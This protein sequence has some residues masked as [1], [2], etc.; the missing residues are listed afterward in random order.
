[1]SHVHEAGSARGALLHESSLSRVLRI[2]QLVALVI[3]AVIMLL[4]LALFAALLIAV[5]ESAAAYVAVALIL[6]ACLAPVGLLALCVRRGMRLAMR[7]STG[8]IEV[9]GYLRD[10]WEQV[11]RVETSDH[12]YW[13]RATRIV[14]TDGRRVDAVV[15]SYQFLVFRG[16]AYDDTARDPRIPQLPTRIAID[17]HRR[18][19]RGEFAGPR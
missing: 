7:V 6:V 1:M 2:L 17:A 15:T 16:E 14:T 12:W 11:A 18:F 10:H 9:R 19:L 13:R 4:T 3:G 8:G 5:A